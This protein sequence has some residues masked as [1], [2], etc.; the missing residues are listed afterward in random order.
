MI[1]FKLFVIFC[2]IIYVIGSIVGAFLY[3]RYIKNKRGN[4][5][6]FYKNGKLAKTCIYFDKD[7]YE[8]DQF[9]FIDNVP[10][11][12][13]LYSDQDEDF[14]TLLFFYSDDALDKCKG[15]LDQLGVELVSNFEEANKDG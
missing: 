5:L 15:T 6:D 11:S 8:K 1:S 13:I 10:V 3:R 7:E 2:F 12:T 9:L 4:I 14:A